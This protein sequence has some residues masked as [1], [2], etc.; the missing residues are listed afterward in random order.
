MTKRKLN[1]LV[2]GLNGVVGRA[3]RGTL[4]KRYNLSALSRSGVNGLPKE[5]VHRA[6]IADF[7]GIK[8]AFHN[9]DVVLNLAAD[10]GMSSASGMDAGWDSMLRNNIIGTY[11]VLQAA[12]ES[13]VSRVILI[14]QGRL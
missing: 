10:G 1:V 4:Q 6:D 5:R 14:V 2:T 13:G 12:K 9:M 7:G 11:N 8:P 3:L